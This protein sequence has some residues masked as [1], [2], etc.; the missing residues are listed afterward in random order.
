[1]TIH[2]LPNVSYSGL[3]SAYCEDNTT[4]V[5]L[6]GSPTGGTF[7]GNGVSGST[8]VPNN[9]TIGSN[10]ITYTYTDGNGCTDN[11]S[12]DITVAGCSDSYDL[13]FENDC[14]TDRTID[15]V[16]EGLLNSGTNC[17]NIPNTGDIVSVIAEAWVENDECAG[18]ELPAFLTFTAG[19]T[20]RGLRR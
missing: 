7:S 19:A 8:F 12:I 5:T 14:D 15:V 11:A 17:V 2:A 6:T 3:G 9:A 4:P 20:L 13:D 1:M 18:N 10:T 16:I